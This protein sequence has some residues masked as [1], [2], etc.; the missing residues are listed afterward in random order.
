M[1]KDGKIITEA[2]DL[3]TEWQD[4][5][6]EIDTHGI[7]EFGIWQ[8]ND[9][10]SGANIQIR[11]VGVN[12]FNPTLDFYLPI[13]TVSSSKCNVEDHLVEF[14]NDADENYVV[15]WTFGKIVP[16]VQFQALALTAGGAQIDSLTY[17]AW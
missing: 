15:S 8:Q 13:K 4:V 6:S 16:K 10:N 11:L 14:T 3:T 5:G 7:E 12:P 17:T 9:I 1:Y 2:F